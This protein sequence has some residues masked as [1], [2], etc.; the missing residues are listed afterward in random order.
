MV[1][2]LRAPVAAL[3]CTSP[4]EEAEEVLPPQL[5]TLACGSWAGGG[6]PCGRGGDGPGL[7]WGRGARCGLSLCGP[8]E[9]EAGREAAPA[10]PPPPVFPRLGVG[11]VRRAD[12]SR[13]GGVGVP[14]HGSMTFW[15][16]RGVWVGWPG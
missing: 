5:E 9:G 1:W 15:A 16:G 13:A 6:Q 8:A 4:W 3:G 12:V 7:G 11:T 2:A 10:P 14:G